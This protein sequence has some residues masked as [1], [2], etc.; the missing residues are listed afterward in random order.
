MSLVTDVNLSGG[1]F[2]QRLGGLTPSTWDSLVGAN[3]YSSAGW[4]GFCTADYGAESAAA[5]CVR[6]GEPVCAVPYAEPTESLFSSYRWHG[7]L[8]EAGLPAPDPDGIL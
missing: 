5:V 1:G 6:D 8:T 3:F 7:I 4:L 2:A